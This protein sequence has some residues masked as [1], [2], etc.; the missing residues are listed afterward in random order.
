M[1]YVAN[2]MLSW[3]NICIE[4]LECVIYIPDLLLMLN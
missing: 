3:W 1:V 2:E 4:N